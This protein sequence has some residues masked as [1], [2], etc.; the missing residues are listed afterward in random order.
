VIL[1]LSEPGDLTVLRV[2]PHLDAA[3]AQYSWIEREVKQPTRAFY[4]SLELTMP[5][6][7]SSLPDWPVTL[8]AAADLLRRL[9]RGRLETGPVREMVAEF[10]REHP[11][12][13]ADLLVELPPGAPTADYDLL[14]A[15]PRG[16]TLTLNWQADEGAPWPATQSDH[17]AANLVLTVNTTDLTVQ[18]ALLCLKLASDR[19][20]DLMEELVNET[21]LGHEVR[22]APPDVSSEEIQQAADRFRRARGLSSASTT[23]RWLAES[24]LSVDRFQRVMEA[25]VQRRKMRDRVTVDAVEPY[26]HANSLDFEMV[27]FAEFRCDRAEPLLELTKAA[28]PS[29]LQARVGDWLMN[30]SC[31]NPSATIR[32]AWRRDAPAELRAAEVGELVG[33]C[34]DERG[35]WLAV[36]MSREPAMLNKETRAAIGRE[37]FDAWLSERRQAATIRWHWL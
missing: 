3:G 8:A 26:F 9:P 17:W 18:D 34:S 10:N 23:L 28:D 19:Q 30:Y 24:G 31:D 6:D 22:H 4:L 32:Q 36:V 11:D 35:P 1:I 14:L 33:P 37:L 27:R 13:G 5:A 7:P 12:V 15:D 25:L 21:L 29:G 2:L 20:P 16:G